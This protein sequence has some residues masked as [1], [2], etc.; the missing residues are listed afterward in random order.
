MTETRRI[1][2]VRAGNAG[3]ADALFMTHDQVSIGFAE[4]DDDAS[5][6]EPARSAFKDAFARA[7]P[8]ARA[9]AV[10]VWAGQLFR[11]VHDVQI[12]DFIIYPRKIDRTL[13]WG[14]I[15]GPYVYDTEHSVEFAH[16]RSVRWIAQLSRDAFSQG[17]LY[18]LGAVMTL[19]EVKSF[20]DEILR[21][22][23]GNSAAP[24]SIIAPGDDEAQSDIPRDFEE[25][26]RDFIAKKI[27][28]DLKGFPLESFVAELFRAMGYRA[29]AT[30][31]SQDDGIDVIAHRDELGIEPPVLKIQV[32]SH[33]G[34]IG[35]DQVKA[36]YAMIHDRDVGIFIATGNYTKAA[37][38]FARS[39]ANLRLINGAEFVE[40][41]RKFYDTLDPK[42]R[43]FIPLRRV[44]VP[45]LAEPE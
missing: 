5:K 20:A 13:R 43:Q 15:I 24:S 2:C 41:I 12:G 40:L 21:K 7:T 31:A 39:K 34:N 26:T 17:A 4:I 36:F 16:R 32:K 33:D 29:R 27:R 28:T 23:S 8:A 25:T 22:F 18:E 3:Q 37:Q 42:F 1:W 38:E 11:F 45:D 35:P 6:L 14:E 9:S 44:L 30:R 19:F 10:P